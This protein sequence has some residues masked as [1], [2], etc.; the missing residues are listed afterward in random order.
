TDYP[1]TCLVPI[2]EV[3]KD[4]RTYSRHWGCSQKGT[5]VHQHQPFVRKKWYSMV[6][7]LALDEGVIAAKVV[8]GSFNRETF[9]QF[10]QEDILPMTTPFP[11]PWSVLV[12]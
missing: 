11:G 2:D 7:T 3:S 1:A 9:I 5:H 8:E 6:A 10:L 4:D 12:M